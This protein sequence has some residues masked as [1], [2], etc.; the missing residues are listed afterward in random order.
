MRKEE[1]I[2]LAKE[3]LATED[4][5]SRQNDLAFIKREFKRLSNREDENYFEKLQSEEFFKYY[6]ELA[7]RDASLSASTYDDK[8][9]LILKAKDLLANAEIKS[10]IKEFNSVFEDFKHAGKCSK[11]Q[12]DELWAEMKTLKDEVNAKINEHYEAQKVAFDNKKALKEAIIEKAKKVLEKENIKEASQEMDAL[13][14]E[15][16]GVGFAGKSCDEELWNSFNEVRKAFSLKRKEH[17]AHMTEVFKERV[18]AK[19][20]MIK[21]VK[22]ITADAYFTDEEIKQIKN[23]RN[24]WAK[25][26]FAGKDAEDDLWERFNAAIRKYFEEMKFYK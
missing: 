6:D 26:G 4:L 12:D 18:A 5:S 14:E 3:L 24:E 25:I 10:L 20:E 19:E 23:M 15:W 16:K 17:F 9:A 13:M 1:L 7:K 21:K 2:K 22:V 8:K 11:E